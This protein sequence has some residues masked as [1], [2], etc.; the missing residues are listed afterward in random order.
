MII[1][2]PAD[3]HHKPF[4]HQQH[5]PPPIDPLPVTLQHLRF[6]P[7]WQL[8]HGLDSL[9]T[10]DVGVESICVSAVDRRSGRVDCRVG[11]SGD[12]GDQRGVL[13]QHPDYPFRRV[14]IG[15]VGAVPKV[16][17]AG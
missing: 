3:I 12:G 10:W 17:S 7:H 9:M 15:R 5:P 16:L 1:D 4:Y 13:V 11:R 2:I 8:A 6:T 14:P